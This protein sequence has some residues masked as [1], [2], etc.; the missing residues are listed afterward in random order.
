MAPR[1]SNDISR[2]AESIFSRRGGSAPLINND[3]AEAPSMPRIIADVIYKSPMKRTFTRRP[4]ISRR[5]SRKSAEAVPQVNGADPLSISLS[6]ETAMLTLPNEE[7]L[8]AIDNRPALS[9]AYPSSDV[10]PTTGSLHGVRSTPDFKSRQ[11]TVESR[12]DTWREN[13]DRYSNT[14][15]SMGTH[16]EHEEEKPTRK[17]S[18]TSLRWPLRSQDDRPQSSHITRPAL[19]V[20]VPS[21]QRGVLVHNRKPSREN[22][23]FV[24]PEL[25]EKTPTQANLSPELHA[26]EP[27]TAVPVTPKV[28]IRQESSL[29]CSTDNSQSDTDESSS[30]RSEETPRTSMDSETSRPSPDLFQIV[31]KNL[32]QR[33]DSDGSQSFTNSEYSL[34]KSLPPT[35]KTSSSGSSSY[36]RPSPRQKRSP[37]SKS[38][39]IHPRRPGHLK[40]M[41]IKASA[42][43]RSLDKLNNLDDAFLK[44]DPYAS[45]SSSSPSPT[46]TE[47]VGELVDTLK[48]IPGR[49]RSNSAQSC[50]RSVQSMKDVTGG[51]QQALLDLEARPPFS[52][53]PTIPEKSDKRDCTAHANDVVQSVIDSPPASFQDFRSPMTESEAKAAARRRSLTC[54]Q[55]ISEYLDIS[56]L[57]PI[58]GSPVRPLTVLSP[59]KEKPTISLAIPEPIP[60]QPIEDDGD[61]LEMLPAVAASPSVARLLSQLNG[62][63]EQECA[64]APALVIGA[65]SPDKDG[66]SYACRPSGSQ[67]FED[68]TS[69][70]SE[71]ARESSMSNMSALDSFD[72]LEMM[73]NSTKVMHQVYKQN[74][75]FLLKSVC[76]N[77]SLSLWELR[78]WVPPLDATTSPESPVE[79]EYTPEL[80]KKCIAQD[81]KVID[82]LRKL[83]VLRCASFI[84]P[85]TLEAFSS[86]EI[87]PFRRYENALYRIWCFCRIFGGNKR[88]EEDIAGQLD[89]LKG[90]LLA[91][92]DECAATTSTNLACEFGSVLTTAPEHFGICNEDGLSADELYDMTEMWNC[93]SSLMQSYVGKIGHA[94]T[95]SVYSKT[96]VKYGDVQ[97]EEVMLEEWIYYVV[98]HGPDAVVKLTELSD[99]ISAG[100]SLAHNHG[101]MKWNPPVEGTSRSSFFR[102]P[103]ARLYQERITEVARGQTQSSKLSQ[104]E[105]N[106]QKR[107]RTAQLAQEIRLARHS[108]SYPRLPFIDMAHE[109]PMSTMSMFYSSFDP[110]TRPNSNASTLTAMAL[111]SPAIS[112][113][114]IMPP[115]GSIAGTLKTNTP[116]PRAQQSRSPLPQQ[117]KQNISPIEEERTPT[118]AANHLGPFNV[119]NVQTSTFENV[120]KPRSRGAGCND[121]GRK[122][123][124]RPNVPARMSSKRGRGTNYAVMSIVEQGFSAR[125]AT[126]ALK[127]TDTGENVPFAI[128]LLVQQEMAARA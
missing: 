81:K 101:W 54:S 96:D 110:A 87:Q 43:C 50:L 25:T 27:V 83:I 105:Q 36:S 11:R 12:V 32:R 109:R 52:R 65:D 115:L 29:S 127:M 113:R 79:L 74:E 47:V 78:E 3:P 99:H 124:I 111:P 5:S 1:K 48:R 88:R 4:A 70:V 67:T 58:N 92:Q 97:H 22:V 103:V 91:H 104:N 26:E 94:R 33:A 112:P 35:P 73:A 59:V 24:F 80:Y 61:S 42:S 66:R 119:T 122:R 14:I 121:T 55:L 16:A 60:F 77:R 17:T 72:D 28:H 98:S 102:E 30:Y 53:A 118:N 75:L 64:R 76:K 108:S 38:P 84:R 89:W 37:Y 2:R 71:S 56:Q 6:L 23:P 120:T 106:E 69:P 44:T 51:P 39:S 116:P 126:E 34:N 117:W 49:N 19:A 57:S 86:D 13:V 31:N 41:H 125:Q 85:Q 107:M 21:P 15:E 123:M 7:I 8:S 114:T 95:N 90:G 45:S 62:K 82:N 63:S 68:S 9:S 100:F 40:K 128:D 18:D 10:M 20:K 46:L 93:L